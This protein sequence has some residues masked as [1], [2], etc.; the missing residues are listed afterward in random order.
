MNSTE[1]ANLQ[2]FSKKT[3]W[4]KKIPKSQYRK[5]MP[6]EAQIASKGF[7]SLC[8]CL[9]NIIDKKFLLWPL[10]WENI[11]KVRKYSK[12]LY[13]NFLLLQCLNKFCTSLHE[14]KWGKQSLGLVDRHSTLILEQITWEPGHVIS[15][16]LLYLIPKSQTI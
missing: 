14:R 9:D 7:S 5:Q 13:L 11:E 3:K 8:K 4:N 2:N 16:R 12:N 15:F 6:S 1:K 10:F